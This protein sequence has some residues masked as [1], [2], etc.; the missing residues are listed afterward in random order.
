MATADALV[1]VLEGWLAEAVHEVPDGSNQTKIGAEFGWNGVAWCAETCSVAM[2]HAGVKGFW[3]ASVAAAID[4]AKRGDN[5]LK[6][7]GKNDEIRRGDFA[8][9]DWKGQ[10]NP[11]DFHISTVVDAGNQQTFQTIGGNE[12][13]RVMKQWRDRTYISGFIRPAYDTTGDEDMTPE[14]FKTMMET[15]FG[16]IHKKLDSL[17]DEVKKLQSVTGAKGFDVTP[18]Q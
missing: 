2:K 9:F 11:S 6:R 13:N 3:T 12:D 14:Q 1:A 18:K 8:T 4:A 17:T 10:G 15:G 7:I 5:G 16:F